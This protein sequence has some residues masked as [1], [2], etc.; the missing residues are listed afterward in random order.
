VE[1]WRLSATELAQKIASGEVSAREAVDSNLERI[2]AVNGHLNAVTVVLADEARAAA[3]AADRADGPRGP[4]HGVPFT[5][6]ENI[7]LAGTATTQGLPALAEAVSP[8]DAPVVERMRAA[9][10]IPIGR[11]N[12]PDLGLRI[13][14]HSTL[15]G[16]TRNPFDPGVTAGGSSGGEGSALASGIS[17]IGLGND[18]G[19][20]LRNPAHCC[21]IAS[22]KPSAGRVPHAT[23]IPPEDWG[24]A[25]QAMC[26][27]GVMARHVADVRLGLEIVNGF[28]PRDPQSLPVPLEVERPASRRVAVLPEPPG[29]STHPE[30]AA[31]VRRAADALAGAG[32]DV[33]EA[34]PPSYEEVLET[35]GRWLFAD[36]RAEEELLRTVM[37]PDGIRF[38]EF[39]EPL[40][41]PLDPAGLFAASVKRRE[42]QRRWSVFLAEHSLILSPIW[43]QPPFPHSWDIE[44]EA[45]AAATMELMR[46]VMP[47]NFLGLP[48]AA[49]PAGTAA[50]LPA[51]V[52]VMAE[53]FQDLAALE[54]AEAIEQ[55]LG[56]ATPVQPALATA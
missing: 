22:I 32:Y 56:V 10:A 42:I 54:A 6:K 29:G 3:D 43:T 37:G 47:A 48:A 2:E 23:V 12:L 28:D 44:S 49:V 34:V 15:R 24:P 31:A 35:W 50:G 41:P 30:I 45:N 9:G 51:G 1:L 26:V 21:G 11:T 8:V 25:M 16:L 27:E 55:A 36:I 53:R 33:V 20:S 18:V 39:V 40:Y 7:D 4:L 14:T 17:P 13:H 38:L 52:Q 19:G 46:P 5:V